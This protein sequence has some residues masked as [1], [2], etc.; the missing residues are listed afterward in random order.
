MQLICIAGSGLGFY[1][2][3]KLLNIEVQHGIR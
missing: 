1:L 2:P 3:K